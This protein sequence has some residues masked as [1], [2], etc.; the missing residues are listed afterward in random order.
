MRH[1]KKIA[2]V[3]AK[4]SFHDDLLLSLI[5]GKYFDRAMSPCNIN[6]GSVVSYGEVLFALRARNHP[7][8][9][10]S[11]ALFILVSS[12]IESSS[13]NSSSR[14]DDQVME[15]VESILLMLL[16]SRLESFQTLKMV[17]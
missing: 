7:R 4:S 14:T 15:A 16:S 1:A 17:L 2:D 5:L 9:D 10:H 13:Y 8:K 12:F 3:K 11:F 6:A